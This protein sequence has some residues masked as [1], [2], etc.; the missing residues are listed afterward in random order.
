[1]AYG[2][3]KGL[4]KGGKKGQKKKQ[5]D[6]F[7]RKVWYNVKQPSYF[8]TKNRKVGFTP[9]NKTAGTKVET[10]GLKGRV[11][12][13]N[14]VDLTEND[15]DSHKKFKLEVIE[16]QGKNC[17]TDFH[18][19]G[20]TRDKLCSLM[21]KKH[22]LIEAFAD[23]K[24][25]DGYVVRLF[26][27]ALTA[28]LQNQT[29]VFTYAQTSAVRKIR[30]KMVETMQKKVADGMM[31][32]TVKNLCADTIETDITK[33]CMRIF[34][35]RDVHIFKAKILKKPKMDIVKL[36][37]IHTNATDDGAPVAKDEDPESKNLLAA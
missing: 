23:C 12:E 17:L 13:F 19:M 33:H 22:T 25:T 28:R 37:E 29:S 9:V 8:K 24:T 16:T 1:M 32:D 5:A 11:C 18:S 30:K 26:C 21:K 2:K 3:N 4:A 20:F 27:M 10:D 15:G 31:R 14:A 6:P 35:L 36:M 7:S 34:P